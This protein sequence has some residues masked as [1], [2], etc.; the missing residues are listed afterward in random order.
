MVTR[1]NTILRDNDRTFVVFGYQ[2]KKQGSGERV[3]EQEAVTGLAAP[4]CQHEITGA[5]NR[6]EIERIMAVSDNV[7]GTRELNLL[8]IEG[9]QIKLGAAYCESMAL[10]ANAIAKNEVQIIPS[11]GAD[12][13]LVRKV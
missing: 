1:D 9:A 11:Y 6:E 12:V 3:V 10:L 2:H 4:P 7:F 8:D 5:L 13:H